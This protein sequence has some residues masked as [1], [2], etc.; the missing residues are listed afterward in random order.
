MQ[1]R[2]SIL[3]LALVLIGCHRQAIW[4]ESQIG[5]GGYITG[6]QQNPHNPN[7]LYCRSDVGGVFR[8]DDGGQTWSAKNNGMDKWYQHSVRSL[9]ID[10][11]SPNIVYR[12]SGNLIGHQ[13]C[14]YVHISRDGG[15]T[16][17]LLTDSIDFYG[18]GPTRMC[19]EMIAIHP[20][21]HKR[22]VVGG[23][24]HGLW[25]SNNQGKKWQYVDLRDERIT[26]VKY[27]EFGCLY[28]GTTFD[29]SVG[30]SAFILKSMDHERNL[31]SRVYKYSADLLEKNI[32]YETYSHSIYDIAI[33]NKDSIL[34]VTTNRGLLRSV[35]GEPFEWVED[36]PQNGLIQTIAVS[37]IH[38]NQF[39]TA[40][41]F[42]TRD[43][44]MLFESLDYGM[45]WHL[46]SENLTEKSF[47]SYPSYGKPT[48][49]W[50]GGSIAAICPDFQDDKTLYYGNYW[51]VTTTHDAGLNF[52]CYEFTGLGILCGEC[53]IRHSSQSNAVLLGM[54][55]H[56]PLIS[57][58]LGENYVLFSNK[59]RTSTRTLATARSN[60]DFLIWSE[61]SKRTYKG[62]A[63]RRTLD[64]GQSIETV[65]HKSGNSYVQC[66]I[67]DPI[68]DGVYYIMQEGLFGDSIEAGCIYQSSDFGATWQLLPSPYPNYL[69]QIPYRRVYIDEDY[70]PVICYQTKNASGTNQLMTMDAFTENVLYV[71]EWTEGIWRSMDG[72]QT[73]T[74]ISQSL[75]MH[76]DTAIVLSH[77]YA[78]PNQAGSLYAGFWKC[79]LWHS[80]DYGDT[81]QH[82]NV[83][84]NAVS[85]TK[86]GCTIVVAC[87]QHI[88][89]D[90]P[91]QLLISEDNG[92]HWRDIYDNS[93]GALRMIGITLDSNNRRI[94]VSTCGN[95]A[96]WVEY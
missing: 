14:G 53:I 89:S 62:T 95:G 71:G 69:K 91:T 40:R 68:H 88:Y 4:H 5:G 60:P 33:A 28:V 2:F 19:G 79:G 20:F 32:L 64:G 3:A 66:L 30:N 31:P 41:K 93:L 58:D 21:N 6:I 54:A 34:L 9:V 70:L 45:S 15:D 10:T 17:T 75:P 81:W 11:M 73:W 13:Y 65:M 48:C 74:D 38:P 80:S 57:T 87:S 55:D 1:I 36:V 37:P 83:C 96:Y 8:S 7:V 16:W 47:H 25:Q 35:C 24:S 90:V 94:H 23:Y 77:L 56:G 39:F 76:N 67:E 84:D 51:G 78:D 63:V 18:N 22:I 72:G 52:H 44:L 49:D 43:T 27:D 50:Y 29:C 86:E 59:A 42:S 82:M 85:I 12:A 92:R 26:F 61:G 46:Y